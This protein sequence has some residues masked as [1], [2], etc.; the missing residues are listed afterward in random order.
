MR[1]LVLSLCFILVA[2]CVTSGTNIKVTD[3]DTGN[4]VVISEDGVELDVNVI[5]DDNLLIEI[6]KNEDE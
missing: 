6:D 1:L 4:S 3:K 2:G 5:E